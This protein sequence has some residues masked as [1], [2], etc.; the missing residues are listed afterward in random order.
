VIRW[1]FLLCFFSLEAS[2]G[3]IAIDDKSQISQST[4][5]R[6]KHALDF[7]KKEKPELIVLKLDTPGG[8]IFSSQRI[9][10]ALKKMDQQEGI[11]VVAFIDNWAISAGAMLA[12]SCRHIAVVKDASMGAAEPITIQGGKMVTASEKV[13]SALRTDFA[14]RARLFDRNP[15]I[16][17]A[18]VDKDIILVKRSG[19][20]L[21]LDKEDQV[22]SSDDVI[23]AKGKLLTLG[24]EDLL[25][26][27]VV[28]YLVPQVKLEPITETEQWP[29]SKLALFHHPS[30]KKYESEMVVPYKMDWKTHLLVILTHPMVASV[31]FLAMMLGFYIEI[32][33]PGFGVPGSVGLIALSLLVMSSFALD[34]AS[35]LEVVLLLL[36]LV[37]VAL[38]LFLIPTFGLLGVVG[39]VMAIAG[40]FGI[41]LPGIADI[42]YEFDTQ[43]FNAAGEAFLNRLA[44]FSGSLVVAVVIMVLLAKYM[45]LTFSGFNKIVLTGSEQEGY[46]A[47]DSSKLPKLG[48][49]GTVYATLRPAGKVEIEGQV[50]DAVTSGE[51]IE[52]GASVVIKQVDGNVMVVDQE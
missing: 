4:W 37:L 45:K 29:A 19:R 38:D 2:I 23:S 34:I 26:L 10:D 35:W 27:K 21:R 6:I 51:F 44:W 46:R 41:L 33:S 31:L 12:Y 13:N 50:Y 15:D 52:K 16:A 24:T 36:G 14:N 9:S 48:T 3:Y 7:Y 8:E 20:V 28:E 40:L 32:N 43:T 39:I 5:I 25:D 42:S 11:P 30:F 1:L 17:E 18:M 47:G 49:K 22:K